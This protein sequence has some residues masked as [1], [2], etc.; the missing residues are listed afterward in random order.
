MD[1]IW[2][3]GHRTSFDTSLY[4]KWLQFLVQLA[5]KLFHS[6]M[7]YTT[8]YFLGHGKKGSWE[9]WNAFPAVSSAFLQ[10][11]NKPTIS[12]LD[13]CLP[14]IE[15][16]VILMYDRT[17]QKYSMDSVRKHLFAKG[18][19]MEYLPPFKAALI[20]HIKRACL[21][22]GHCWG[23]ALE[24]SPKLPCP[25]L[26]AWQKLDDSWEP[27]WTSLFPIS[28]CCP[29]LISCKCKKGCTKRCKRKKACLPCTALCYCDGTCRE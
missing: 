4:T 9:T 28:A 3:G 16:F 1:S 29:K 14:L 10:L 11:S 12:C 5:L 8:S 24:V 22:A 19:Q 13:E 20:E 6:A 18:R 17:S 7:R 15:R 26:W 25:S 2:C 27:S 23:S 21:Q